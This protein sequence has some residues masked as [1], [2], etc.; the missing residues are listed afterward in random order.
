VG[1][2]RLFVVWVLKGSDGSTD[3]RKLGYHIGTGWDKPYQ[4]LKVA[5]D[6]SGWICLGLIDIPTVLPLT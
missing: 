6:G 5:D 3:G 1:T 2:E 4:F